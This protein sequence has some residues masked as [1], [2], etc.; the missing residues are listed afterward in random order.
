MKQLMRRTIIFLFI[1]FVVLMTAEAR[2]KNGKYDKKEQGADLALIEP[3][4]IAHKSKPD[5]HPKG[6]KQPTLYVESDVSHIHGLDL[7]HYQGRVNW[8]MVATD[9]H[10][11]YIYLK[12]T[13]GER[14]VDDTYRYNFSE[15]K[16][17]GLK[18]G[19]YHFFR[20]GISAV[21]QFNNFISVVNVKEQDLLPIV[22]VE[23][24]ARGVS[25][26]TFY[27]RLEEFLNLVTRE[28]GKRPI[29]YTGKNFYNKH[30]SNRRFKD[31]KFMIAAYTLDEPELDN[32]DDY[33]IW[34][35]TGSGS[36]KGIRGH[37]DKSRFRGKH[38][39]SEILF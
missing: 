29:I 32:N 5:F 30:F 1:S 25:M 10:A 2:K 13:E 28:F 27:S 18:V 11:G 35:Y 26:A 23:V 20:P 8:D 38:S 3:D 37:V 4:P 21:R 31:Y 15:V 16:R 9:P 34:Q 19:S 33:I 14:L 6:L 36:A 17:V 39:I 12:A 7:S 24:T 22:D